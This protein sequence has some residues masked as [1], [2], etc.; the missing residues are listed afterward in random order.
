MP[1]KANTPTNIKIVSISSLIAITV[2]FF[3]DIAKIQKCLG[4][5]QSVSCGSAVKIFQMPICGV[6]SVPD[7]GV[8]TE[9]VVRC[10]NWS[11]F[12]W[13]RRALIAWRTL[14][15]TL[16]AVV[17]VPQNSAYVVS[18]HSLYGLCRLSRLSLVSNLLALLWLL[19]IK[20]VVAGS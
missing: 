19:C 6:W 17:S 15:L 2:S 11:V 18:I 10:L 3:D 1:M 5:D 13:Q 9:F 16:S 14:A 4:H 12:V 20:A 7:D 8:E